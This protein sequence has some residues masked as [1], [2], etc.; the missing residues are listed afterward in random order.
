MTKNEFAQKRNW[1]KHQVDCMYA[2]CGREL[3]LPFNNIISINE[4]NR[5]QTISNYLSFLSEDWKE[6]TKEL[7]AQV[8]FIVKKTE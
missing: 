2:M 5:L 8:I 4:R 3:Q 6:E 1:F 7:K